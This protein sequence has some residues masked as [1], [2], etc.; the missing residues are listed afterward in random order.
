[1][2]RRYYR[3]G[4]FARKSSVSIRTL[5]YYD[6]V[7]L[8]APAGHS[9]A[10]YRLYTDDDLSRLQQIVALKYL[11]FSLDEITNCLSTGPQSLHGALRA[12][13]AMMSEKRAQIEAII[14]AIEETERVVQAG[15]DSW[16]AIVH[17]MEAIQVSQ[18]EEWQNK[19]FTPEQRQTLDTLSQQ[20]YSEEARQKLA[21][22]GPWTEEDQKRV[23]E[24]YAWIGGELKRL[25]AAGADPASPEAQAVAR[26]QHELLS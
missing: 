10:G 17:V 25:V 23:N 24:Q 4:Q 7:G 16:D 5:R 15:C 18:T 6:Q 14:Q 21:V 8:L 2:S 3:V 1:M 22:R 9:E 20:S 26:L 19:Y 11:G 13:K 12:Q